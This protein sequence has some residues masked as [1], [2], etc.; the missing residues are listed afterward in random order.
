[1]VTLG[2]ALSLPA[3]MTAV[4]AATNA[5]KVAPKSP[6]A[7]VQSVPHAGALA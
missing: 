2:D 5:E 1:M 7:L 4:D 3:A 6:V